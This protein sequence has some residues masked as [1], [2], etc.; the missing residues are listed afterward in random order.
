M[1]ASPAERARAWIHAREDVVCDRAEPWAHGTVLRATRHPDYWDYNLVRVE[2]DLDLSAEELA[3]VADAALADARHRR[4]D[5]EVPRTAER[6]RPGFTALGWQTM[7]LVL[8][9]HEAPAPPGPAVA[10]EEVAY[11]EAD[12]LR[13]AW[14]EEDFPGVDQGGYLDQAREVAL[15]RGVRVLVARGSDGA[16]AGFAQLEHD[17]DAAEVTQVFVHPAHRGAG[18][19]TALTCAAITAA[20]DVTDLWIAADDEDRPKELYARLG[21]RPVWTLL[22]LTRLPG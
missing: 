11:E 10:V 20:G 8:M 18:L 19:G 14:H 7:R 15:R 22:E 5:V 6:L 13:R 21:F 9:R 4:I 12:A 3:A 1:A 17:G 2:E 16:T